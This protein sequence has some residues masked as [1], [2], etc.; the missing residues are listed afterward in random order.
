MVNKNSKKSNAAGAKLLAEGQTTVSSRR[1][2]QLDQ[3]LLAEYADLGTKVI[4][5]YEPDEWFRMAIWKLIMSGTASSLSS[6]QLSGSP[7]L[8]A[9]INSWSARTGPV[10]GTVDYDSAQ[11]PSPTLYLDPSTPGYHPSTVATGTSNSPSTNSVTW[12]DAS[13][14]D[15][16]LV[17]HVST[18]VVTGITNVIERILT[19]SLELSRVFIDLCYYRNYRLMPAQP[20]HSTQVSLVARLNKEQF[21]GRLSSDEKNML[22]QFMMALLMKSGRTNAYGEGVTS[23][24]RSASFL[25]AHDIPVLMVDEGVS[26]IYAPK[27]VVEGRGGS[28]LSAVENGFITSFRS[29]RS[30][31]SAM[32]KMV[33][34]VP[35]IFRAF[36]SVFFDEYPEVSLDDFGEIRDYVNFLPSSRP[37]AAPS[38]VD[39]MLVAEDLPSVLS[40]VRKGSPT[41]PI[42]VRPLKTM[43]GRFDTIERR[44]QAVDSSEDF[45]L[46]VVAPVRKYEG[47]SSVILERSPDG[48]GFAWS[49]AEKSY[50]N[51][52]RST[53]HILSSLIDLATVSTE[54]LLESA[55]ADLPQAGWVGFVGSER[56]LFL[57]AL[58]MSD[59]AT[60]D[61][62][63]GGLL[64]ATIDFRFSMRGDVPKTVS[65]LNLVTDKEQMTTTN[66]ASVI[67]LSDNRPHGTDPFLYKDELMEYLTSRTHVIAEQGS[68]PVGARATNSHSV[69]VPSWPTS[70]GP[71]GSVV[72]DTTSNP[73]FVDVDLFLA[74]IDD[75]A[76]SHNIRVVFSPWADV[77]IGVLHS[78]SLVVWSSLSRALSAPGWA[79][80]TGATTESILRR[81]LAG[82]LD[83][84]LWS[85]PLQRAV[86]TVHERSGVVH[87]HV[88]TIRSYEEAYNLLKSLIGAFMSVAVDHSSTHLSSAASWWE[89][90]D[91]NVLSNPDLRNEVAVNRRMSALGQTKRRFT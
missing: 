32:R 17:N 36:S 49:V 15:H 50:Y 64:S 57:L 51:D 3:S 60:L 2:I 41:F 59:S 48:S 69:A 38:Q 19:R 53:E 87:A 58:A 77:S 63:D 52:G 10:I 81:A 29:L 13:Y 20:F 18:A 25:V 5:W 72:V 8:A 31:L 70:I 68:L 27:L 9:S 76:M 42:D 90:I 43:L 46:F 26:N 21:Y 83:S 86:S 47:T 71:R 33:Q 56:D 75:T 4:R 34:G 37:A 16:S 24:S 85:V 73:T 22:V 40:L 79:S 7:S 55:T 30:E 54:R 84:W 88:N 11:V 1:R 78:V 66:P 80:M 23:V 91:S 12:Q 65:P 62:G 89:W 82:Y 39:I 44:V 61:Y 14:L 6:A 67:V 28:T 45:S 35:R 74:D